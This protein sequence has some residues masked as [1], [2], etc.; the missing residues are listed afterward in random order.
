MYSA[1]KSREEKHKVQDCIFRYYNNPVN[2]ALMFP[3]TTMYDLRLGFKNGIFNF[4]TKFIF[5]ENG[6]CQVFNETINGL[7]EESKFNSLRRDNLWMKKI[8]F[9]HML[10]LFAKEESR[11]NINNIYLHL[12]NFE[13]LDLKKALNYLNE[14]KVDFCYFDFCGILNKKMM[15][16]FRFYRKYIKDGFLAFT[17]CIE[18]FHRVY[19]NKYGKIKF[20]DYY[21]LLEKEKKYEILNVSF[22]G[23]SRDLCV[24]NS[25]YLLEFHEAVFNKVPEYIVIYKDNKEKNGLGMI[26]F[27]MSNVISN[28]SLKFIKNDI[29]KPQSIFDKKR[30]SKS[31]EDNWGNFNNLKD[32]Y[33]SYMHVSAISQ[34]NILT[35]NFIEQ[36][37]KDF[38]NIYESKYKRKTMLNDNDFIEKI[39]TLNI[40]D[41]KKACNS[42]GRKSIYNIIKKLSINENYHWLSYRISKHQKM[43]L[44]KFFYNLAE[45]RILKISRYKIV[46]FLDDSNKESF[47]TETIRNVFNEVIK[48]LSIEQKINLNKDLDV[49][50]EKTDMMLTIYDLQEKLKKFETKF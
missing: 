34:F 24:D 44:E 15:E 40:E 22:E 49:I 20:S 2:V 17:Y 28:S 27:I 18:S 3:S 16:W 4:N 6:D 32:V 35:E 25:Q 13:T 19:N 23:G 14:E 38:F 10:S 31:Y 29:I 39:S 37:K 21:G 5:I 42:I 48:K 8:G 26:S 7:K 36:N 41:I 11:L 9:L 45:K 50:L 12:D 43:L 33:L 1:L 47:N 30:F 46:K